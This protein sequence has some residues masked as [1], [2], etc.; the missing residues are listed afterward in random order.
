[1]EGFEDLARIE[2]LHWCKRHRR[3]FDY[4]CQLCFKSRLAAIIEMDGPTEIEHDD[5]TDKTEELVTITVNAMPLTLICGDS[6][7]YNR[8]QFVA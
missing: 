5:D 3:L 7:S 6:N 2:Q 4:C 1:M 8:Y